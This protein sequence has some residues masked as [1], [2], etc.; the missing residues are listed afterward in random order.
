MKR[1]RVPI[2][3]KK[4]VAFILVSMSVLVV[5]F[6]F[7]PFGWIFMIQWT[8]WQQD[9]VPSTFRKNQALYTSI[10][11]KAKHLSN[12]NARHSTFY[13]DNRFDP[14]SLSATQK[15]SNQGMTGKV[16]VTKDDE[17]YSRVDITVRDDGHMGHTIFHYS[18]A[19]VTEANLYDNCGKDTLLSEHWIC[20]QNN[21]D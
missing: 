21:C 3:V 19:R 1:F 13:L 12:S 14:E 6:L 15:S 2:A 11:A 7:P 4:T 20:E 8:H 16:T 17:G 9:R 18:D 5:L 10:V